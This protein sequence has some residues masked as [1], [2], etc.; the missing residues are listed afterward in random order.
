MR[1]KSASVLLFV[2]LFSESC[3]VPRDVAYF[4]GIDTLTPEQVERMNQ[5]YSSRVCKD[6]L[7]TITVTGWDPT[8]LTPFNPPAYAYAS[9]GETDITLSQQLQT[10]L[11]DSEGYI[12]FPVL[13]KVKA[14]GFSKQDLAENIR[15]GVCEYVPDV[16]VNVQIVN[17]KVT[18][19]GEVSRPGAITVR[20]DRL[21][22]IDAIGQVG[23]LTINADRKNILVI[24]ES[25]G[26]KEY[27]RIDVTGTDLFASPY[28]YL[29]Q[30][31]I[32][33]VEPNSAKKRNA[34]YS[35][36]QQYNI[37]IFS[38]VMSAVSVLSTLV[39]AIVTATRK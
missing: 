8:V 22:I 19:M 35:Q 7:L 26:K 36:A 10:Y 5:T 9:Q 16:Q 39:L 18:L 13:G 28:F 33:Y 3:S 24:R 20:N 4:Q 34:R 31:D 27:G 14:S 29:R 30:N 37:T 2:I 12:V 32:V 25:D 1:L 21:T 38:S 17:Y 23:D 11:V 6:D 15:K